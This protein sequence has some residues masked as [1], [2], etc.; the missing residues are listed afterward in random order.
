MSVV[1]LQE[2]PILWNV[3]ILELDEILLEKGKLLRSSEKCMQINK[4]HD[5]QINID[6]Y[7]RGDN[8]VHY[9]HR[10]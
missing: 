2:L 10:L 3:K 4:A 1:E 8:W 6:A 9:V 5:I 7:L